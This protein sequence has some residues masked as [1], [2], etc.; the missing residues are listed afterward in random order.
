LESQSIT[1]VDTNN[2]CF[3]VY[4]AP[5]LFR[6]LGQ[7]DDLSLIL[8]GVF[9]VLQL[10]TVFVCFV[11]I[12]KVGRKTLAIIGAAGT[13]VAYIVIAVLSALYEDSWL[14]HVAAGW[15]AVAFAFLFILFFGVSFSPLGWALP[16][17]VFPTSL[18]SKGVALSNCVNWL[19]NFTVAIITPPL[20]ASARFGTYVFFAVLCLG[21]LL[22]A[23]FLLPET[24]GKSL[25][26]LDSVFGDHTGATESEIMGM[27]ARTNLVQRRAKTAEAEV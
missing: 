1:L 13:A 7:S 23:L 14:E 20:I 17:E 25:E 15:A 21:A 22:W 19:S 18:R 11:I 27:V 10:V 9:N 6:Q 24:K 4:Y 8:S 26:D 16:T 2:L 5:T 3:L 12:D